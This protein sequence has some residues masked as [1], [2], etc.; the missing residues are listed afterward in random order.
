MTKETG[1]EKNAGETPKG[2]DD[3]LCFSVSWNK[4]LDSVQAEAAGRIYRSHRFILSG[5]K[6]HRIS[7]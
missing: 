5:G 7:I 1:I 3:M 6:Y 2:L 4:Y